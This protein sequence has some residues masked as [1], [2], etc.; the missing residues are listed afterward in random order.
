MEHAPPDSFMFG[1]LPGARYKSQYYMSRLLY[2]HVM[3]EFVADCFKQIIE[4]NVQHWNFQIT[5][6][7]WSSIP[8]MVSLSTYLRMQGI[9]I[10]TFMI[11][12]QRKTYGI[13]NYI[14]GRP[15]D[16]PVLIVDDVLNS[17]NS[18][19]HCNAVLKS[20]EVQLETLPFIFA[21]LNKYRY[22]QYVEPNHDYYD[23][24]LG[25]NHK[26]LSILTGDDI[27]AVR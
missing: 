5:G 18:F 1:K 16:L 20:K 15:N 11:K 12:R 24:Y 8:L 23:R 10:N 25:R 19:W 2:N 6:R 26:A 21:V 3:M 14:E 9:Y 4:E 13:H 27:D 17:T 22:R 7:E